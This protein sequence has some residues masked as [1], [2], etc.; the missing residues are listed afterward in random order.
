MAVYTV[1]MVPV[2]AVAIIVYATNSIAKD[3]RAVLRSRRGED[4]SLFPVAAVA[5]RPAASAL[6]RADAVGWI[7][8]LC[9]ASGSS[10]TSA[11]EGSGVVRF[12]GLER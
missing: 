12:D 4:G 9:G 7:R 5:V 2:V 6:D 1:N 3:T 10:P 11:V 8:G